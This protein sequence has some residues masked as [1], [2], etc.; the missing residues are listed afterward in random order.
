MNY[1]T[2]NARH[3]GTALF[4]VTGW[5]ATVFVVMLYAVAGALPGPDDVTTENAMAAEI[6]SIDRQQV[7]DARFAKA[8]QEMCGPQSAWKDLGN[9]QIQCFTHKGRPTVIAKVSL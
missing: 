5:A 1:L 3:V 2:E 4:S 9:S 7:R 6:Q 8:A